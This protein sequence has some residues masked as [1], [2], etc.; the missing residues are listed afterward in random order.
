MQHLLCYQ[1]ER[2][3]V[4]PGFEYFRV[5]TG[6]PVAIFLCVG[7]YM[8]MV[9]YSTARIEYVSFIRKR[10]RR[11]L[12]PYLSVSVLIILSRIVLERLHLMPLSVT[13]Y[14]P[15]DP[16]RIIVDLLFAGASMHLYFLPGLFLM[17]ALVPL[18]K[19][20]LKK[21]HLCFLITVWY[22]LG[23]KPLFFMLY[24][25]AGLR[26]PEPD[27]ILNT[28][29]GFQYF[30]AGCFLF[31]FD[32]YADYFKGKNGLFFAL[33]FIL[34]AVQAHPYVPGEATGILLVLGYIFLAK[35]LEEIRSPILLKLSGL[36]YGVYLIHVP[37]FVKMGDMLLRRME[38]TWTNYLLSS[39]FILV[40]ASGLVM[41]FQRVPLLNLL[42]LGEI[43]APAGTV[44]FRPKKSPLLAIAPKRPAE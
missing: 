35:G 32:K 4:L 28:V 30:L 1:G 26:L 16:K 23:A 44:S 18:M 21:V 40:G 5:A 8:A 19:A 17:Y 13:V 14:T 20:S 15:L 22:I 25:L 3:R 33:I 24:P 39:A 31:H 42:F 29:W 11:I 10:A 41:L 12:L 34:L 27:L 9:S 7:G 36:T 6:W 43:Q 2:L 38:P 37:Y